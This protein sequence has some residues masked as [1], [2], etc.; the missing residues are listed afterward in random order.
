M[1]AIL[2]KCE[3]ATGVAKDNYL[4]QINDLM[5]RANLALRSYK[6]ELIDLPKEYKR[7]YEEQMKGHKT[8]M[9]EIQQKLKWVKSEA[10]RSN[11]L[12]PGAEMAPMSDSQYVNKANELQDD[13]LKSL[14]RS[15]AVVEDAT[16]IGAET[17][18]S[19]KAQ[20]EQLNRISKDV[21]SIANNLKLAEKQLRSFVRRMATDKLILCLLCCIVCAIIALIVVS[22]VKKHHHNPDTNTHSN[23][24]A[25]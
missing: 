11:L 16:N 1:E 3:K 4:Q 20:T 18:T 8:H 5:E 24:H 19:L 2:K 13:S 23:S 25:E 10:D 14:A 6:V 12:G 17:A 15:K 7:R 21:D 9:E 22:V